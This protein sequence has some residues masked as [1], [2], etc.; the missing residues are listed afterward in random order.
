MAIGSTKWVSGP[1][2]T[3]R[4]TK[5]SSEVNEDCELHD[6]LR[7]LVV[8]G[9]DPPLCCGLVA[10]SCLDSCLAG[11]MFHLRTC[12]RCVSSMTFFL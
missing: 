3:G 2:T 8:R 9:F 1:V 7:Q 12:W 11:S 4:T 6:A 5:Y 10:S